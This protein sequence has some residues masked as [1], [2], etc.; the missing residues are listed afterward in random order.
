MMDIKRQKEGQEKEIKKLKQTI[1][2]I[3][4]CGESVVIEKLYNTSSTSPEPLRHLR[5][6][7]E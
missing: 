5:G 4:C 7:K 2:K 1:Y 6:R 3:S